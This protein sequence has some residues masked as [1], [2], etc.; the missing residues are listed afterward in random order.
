MR[1]DG[2]LHSTFKGP[3]AT[4]VP[5]GHSYDDAFIRKLIT[6]DPAIGSKRESNPISKYRVYNVHLATMSGNSEIL[7][8]IEYVLKGES[9]EERIYKKNI[10][11][12][13][14][15]VE[16]YTVSP[17][18]APVSKLHQTTT[19]WVDT[20]RTTIP[21]GYNSYMHFFPMIVFFTS[22]VWNRGIREGT[23]IYGYINGMETSSVSPYG[24]VK[25]SPVNVVDPI[26]LAASL[27]NGEIPL[28]DAPPGI[29]SPESTPPNQL[30]SQHLDAVQP[31]HD[32]N[33]IN[34]TLHDQIRIP[35]ATCS[36]LGYKLFPLPRY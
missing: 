22:K 24:P 11:S 34:P 32:D 28:L 36:E 3:S 15:D 29:K 8:L 19:S 33:Y 18:S 27:G 20:V 2:H 16:I 14:T 12:P 10:D 35:T 5:G 4:S 9:V 30:M 23:P 13:N 25:T 17:T 7:E 21:S 26:P 6:A 1:G 31:G